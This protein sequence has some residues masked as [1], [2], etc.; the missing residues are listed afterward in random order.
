MLPGV[1]QE[2][3]TSTLE[4]RAIE[5]IASRERFENR[6][7]REKSA[8]PWR[9]EICPLHCGPAISLIWER[10]PRK[11]SLDILSHI[12]D[13]TQSLDDA[14]AASKR[15]GGLEARDRAF[16]RRLITVT[17]RRLGEIDARLDGYLDRPLPAKAATIRHILRLGLCQ[18]LF[19]DT[20]P[21]A[22]V[23][24]SVM[25]ARPIRRGAFTGLV[26]ALL[27][28]AVREKNDL[29]DVDAARLNTP[30]WLWRVWSAAYGEETCR[31]I[32]EAHL[33]EPPL[34]LTV[35]TETAAWAE[36]LGGIVLPTGGIRLAGASTV[37]DLPG[38][39]E[40]AWWVQDGAAA[41]PAKLLNVNPGETVIDLCAAPGGK[42][43]QLAGG[44]AHVIAVDRSEKRLKLVKE[45][46]A[47]LKL[48]AEVIC[49]DALDWMP[50]APADAI[51]V[52]AP[53][54][55]TGTIRRH[56]D[57]PWTKSDADV[58]AAAETQ[59]QILTRAI[60]MVR[61][62]G[63]IVFATCSLD[64]REGEGLAADFLAANA[65]IER[66]PIAPE[67]IG[68][69]SEL[70]TDTGELRTLPCHLANL[71]GMD[72]FYAVRLKRS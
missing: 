63:R 72:G 3:L 7:L 49:A 69:I 34:D 29:G 9:R 14:L 53:C 18:I 37:T 15:F 5:G 24:T 26:N 70:I 11:A 67:E 19:L 22:A 4:H 12:L 39:A 17:L 43:A 31:H 47:R 59:R 51:L 33:G 48:S 62:G 42:T 36:K 46:L 55:A 25:L 21:H 41:L 54:S 10:M 40:G 32:A 52:D 61:P 58:L 64:P 35:K 50:D 28:R 57:I 56:P 71:G 68:G 6:Y 65:D 60:Q 23:D 44:G 27:R 45:N 38:F 13:R 16:A 2:A 20:P 30:D 66:D 8:R 1:R